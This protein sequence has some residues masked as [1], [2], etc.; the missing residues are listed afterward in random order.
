MKTKVT[1]KSIKENF[2]RV[3]C[4]GYCDMQSLLRH[5][6]PFS[7]SCGSYGWMCDYYD[8]GDICISTGYN[9]TGEKVNYSVIREF[10]EKAEKICRSNLPNEKELLNDLITHNSKKK[11]H[12]S[13]LSIKVITMAPEIRL[14]QMEFAQTIFGKRF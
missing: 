1:K 12:T 3:L 10:E 4:V 13:Y 11:N 2:I 7:Y 5:K 14:I 8:F 9:P 6:N